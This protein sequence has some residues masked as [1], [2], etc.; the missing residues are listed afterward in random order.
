M[1]EMAPLKCPV[2][3]LLDLTE[4][5]NDESSGNSDKSHSG[6]FGREE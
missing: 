5:H 2:N 4:F 3:I 1:G 6:F